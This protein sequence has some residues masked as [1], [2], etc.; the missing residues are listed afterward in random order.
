M[1]IPG[2]SVTEGNTSGRP[3]RWLL[4]VAVALLSFL[5]LALSGA[6]VVVLVRGTEESEMDRIFR[7]VPQNPRTVPENPPEE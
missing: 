2:G 3:T 1:S 5:F 7:T 6:A 4:V